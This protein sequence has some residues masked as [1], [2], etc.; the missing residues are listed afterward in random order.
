MLFFCD[1][2]QFKQKTIDLFKNLF[3]LNNEEKKDV[4]IDQGGTIWNPYSS[5]IYF[6]NPRCFII[7]RDPRDIF[8]E[9]KRKAAHRYPGNDVNIFCSWYKKIISQI[10]E[11]EAKKSNI[12]KLN[13]EDFVFNHKE[14]VSSISDHISTNINPE[15]VEFDL[16]RPKKNVS[17]YIQDLSKEEILIIEKE[18]KNFLYI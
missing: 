5:T 11:N 10:D 13:F 17:R 3:F 12:L 9:F 15:N 7:F 2:D 16:L 1:E 8:S 18:L 4:I 6:D 14:T